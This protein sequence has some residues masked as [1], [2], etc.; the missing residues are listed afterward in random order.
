ML[1]I[2]VALALALALS[3]CSGDR[4]WAPDDEVARA[5]YVHDG[6]PEIALFTVVNNRS[7]EGGHSAL[8]INADERV[9][10]DP[11]GTWY[12]PWAPI[13]HDTHY[14]ITP[15]IEDRYIDYHTRVT[16]RTVV[17]RLPVTPEVAARALAAAQS[18][19]PVPNAFCAD[20]TSD[21][22]RQAGVPV[23]RTMF[24]NRLKEAFGALPGVSERT[25][26]DT[27]SDDNSGILAAQQ[28]QAA[29]G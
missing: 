22:L 23:A 5:R 14:G 19:P 4:T 29:G 21:I 28:R 17:Q 7:G 24:P 8:M 10:F 26:T 11:A 18:Y 27:D 12:H 2:L 3:A 20:S 9:I 25:Y 15:Q 1:R 16:Y 13:R 6:P